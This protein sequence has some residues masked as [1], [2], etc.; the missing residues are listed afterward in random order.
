MDVKQQTKKP[1][2]NQK[3]FGFG[4]VAPKPDAENSTAHIFHIL[5]QGRSMEMNAPSQTLTDQDEDALALMGDY[6][7]LED[8]EEAVN[9]L[10]AIDRNNGCTTD[11]IR[12]SKDQFATYV[13]YSSGRIE[14]FIHATRE[15][16]V[17]QTSADAQDGTREIGAPLVEGGIIETLDSYIPEPIRFFDID[18]S[19]IVKKTYPALT[20]EDEAFVIAYNA[21]HSCLSRDHW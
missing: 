19:R 10:C 8:L 4:F 2:L 13:H 16:R 18:P 20:E 6:E 1:D 14:A 15:H 9:L 5:A 7:D 3:S 12:M 21:Q 11:P 17:I